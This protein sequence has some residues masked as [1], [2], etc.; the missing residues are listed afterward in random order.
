MNRRRGLRRG[1]RRR[2]ERYSALSSVDQELSVGELIGSAAVE[3]AAFESL[4][5]AKEEVVPPCRAAPA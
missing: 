2:D 3:M 4:K 1:D 5:D